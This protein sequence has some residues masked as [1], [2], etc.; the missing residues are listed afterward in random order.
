MKL[1]I[2]RLLLTLV[3]LLA[4]AFNAGA[5]NFVW[6]ADFDFRF[7]NREYGDPSKMA[8]PSGTLFG[9]N[10]CPEAG[11]EWGF[12]NKLMLGTTIPADMGSENF[13][14][15]PELMAYYAWDGLTFHSSLGLFPRKKLLGRYSYAFFSDSYRFY[16]PTIEGMLIQ[17]VKPQWFV[18]LACDW[19]GLRSPTRREMFTIIF[20][21]EARKGLSYAG[22]T[23]TLHHHASSDTTWGVVD[24]GLADF[25]VGLDFSSLWRGVELRVQGAIVQAYQN[26]RRNVGAAIL[27]NGYELELYMTR[28][29]V[30]LRNTFYKGDDLMPYWNAPYEDAEG[31]PYADNLYFGDPFYRV[32]EKGFYN[33]TELFWE[34]KLKD[35]VSLRFS[36]VHHYDGA[37]WGWQQVVM[38]KVNI[39]SDMFGTIR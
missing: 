10:L 30:G 32:G 5:Q 11:I 28:K 3:A 37:H 25:Y 17:Y 8:A 35:G 12:G 2:Y 38:L 39:G 16:K 22:Y 29:D 36:S 7:D 19:N 9:A 27:P 26:D 31:N 20:A 13:M 4:L 1:Q 18:E 33:R 6:N 21:G 15:T 14:G 24:N 34:P 23:A